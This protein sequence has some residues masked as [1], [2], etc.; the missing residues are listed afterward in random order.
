VISGKKTV[1]LEDV[2]NWIETTCPRLL[3]SLKRTVSSGI[4]T[5]A[6]YCDKWIGPKSKFLSPMKIWLM[7]CCV[8]SY[9][10]KPEA[11]SP[12]EYLSDD[13]SMPSCAVWDLLYSSEDDGLSPNRFETKVFN[14]KSPTVMVVETFSD[15]LYCVCTDEEWRYSTQRWG[16][17]GCAVYRLHPR[18]ELLESGGVSGLI[19]FNLKQRGLPQGLFVGSN[20]KL[21]H[22]SINADFSNVRSIEVWGCGSP[23]SYMAQQNQRQ[24]EKRQVEKQQKVP[25]PTNWED[26]PDRMLLEMGGVKTQHAEK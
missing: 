25:L 7:Q 4:K 2:N 13:S 11:S 22:F 21:P 9:L 26:S 1:E 18:V 24:W 16:K 14:Y 19:F 5:A 15:E 3:S 20:P 10:I 6:T 12:A 17:S 23:E 8:P